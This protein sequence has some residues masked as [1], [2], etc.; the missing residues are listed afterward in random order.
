MRIVFGSSVTGIAALLLL[1]SSLPAFADSFLDKLRSYDLNDFALGLKYTTSESPYL[2]ADPSGF[3]YPYL[4]SFRDAAF[5]DDWLIFSGGDVG[6]RWIGKSGWILGGVGRIKTH[7]SSNSDISDVFGIETRKWTVEVAPLVGWRGWPIHINYRHYVEIFG[8]HGGTTGDLEFSLPMEFDWGY[9]VPTVAV[10]RY[11]DD[12]NNYYFGVS[13]SELVPG[14][15]AYSPGA[16]TG[17]QAGVRWGVAIR[18]KWL[19]SGFV[20]H[21][22]LGEEVS[23]SPIVEKDAIWS[24]NIGLAYNADMFQSREYDDHHYRLPTFEIRAG[25]FQDNVD[26]KMIRKPVD[27]GPSEEIDIEDVL[28]VA[29]RETVW[30]IEAIYR[31]N[32]YHRL[33]L[34]YFELGRDSNITLQQD[35]EVGDE[36]FPE[37]TELSV[38]SDNKTTRIAYAFSLINDAQKEI[39]VMAGVH[40]SKI[41]TEFVDVATGDFVKSKVSTPLPVVGAYGNISLGQKTMLGARLQVFRMEYDHFAGSLNFLYLGLQ[42]NFAEKFGAGI[43][44]SYYQMKLDS[45][46]DDLRGSL[47]FRHHG[48]SV[49]ASFFF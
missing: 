16:S 3:V 19:L 12:Y 5:T 14:I 15:E 49:F 33:E 7:G 18:E 39:G 26:S 9:I 36:V 46:D 42:H 11:S 37:G 43:G 32:P 1:L 30:Q 34:A 45:K 28:G 47:R 44:Y 23:N 10:L 24:A 4:T 40:V 21:E 27:G 35:L 2:G 6:L 29:S 20:G 31:F 38:R 8:Q 48:P 13:S 25:F 41:E 22:W 17:Y